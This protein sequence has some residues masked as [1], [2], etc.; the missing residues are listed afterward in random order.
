M[1]YLW[2]EIVSQGFTGSE[3]TV[4]GAVA[5]WRKTGIAVRP[6]AT[7]GDRARTLL[8]RERGFLRQA[9]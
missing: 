8:E 9:L 3:T 1:R 6:A 2:R 4:R 7:T 5:K